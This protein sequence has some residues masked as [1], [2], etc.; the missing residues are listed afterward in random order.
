MGFIYRIVNKID[1]KTY[2]GQT[3]DIDI[4][5]Y[6]HQKRKNSNCRYLKRAFDKH[7]IDNFKFEII[8]ICFDDDMND[9]EIEYIRKF[10]TL[11]PH[12]YNLREGGN[13]GKHHEETKEKI[14]QSIIDF[15]LKC[16][17]RLNNKPQLGKP[18]SQE[19]RDKISASNRG[20]KASEHARQKFFQKTTCIAI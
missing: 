17:N 14:R 1:M 7:G 9:L 4:R 11:A 10:K 2:I 19:V 16:T 5:W 15:N 8:C 3:Y 13:N 18:R 20:K 12:G 6:T